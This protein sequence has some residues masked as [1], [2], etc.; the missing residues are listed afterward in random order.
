MRTYCATRIRPVEFV[1]GMNGE[2][3]CSPS[4][5][6]TRRRVS[7]MRPCLSSLT[8][9]TGWTGHGREKAG[10][11]GLGLAISKAIIE[12]HDGSI[13]AAHSSLGGLQIQINLPLHTQTGVSE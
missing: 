11:S 2:K 1:S 6:R 13:Q 12:G 9:C 8:A 4:M 5:W 10:G 3:G 7:L